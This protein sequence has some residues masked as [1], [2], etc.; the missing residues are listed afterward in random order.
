M[1]KPDKKANVG[2][3]TDRGYWKVCSSAGMLTAWVPFHDCDEAMGTITMIDGSNRWSGAS[4]G[5]DFFSNDLE[6]IEKN[7]NNGK[8]PVVKAPMNLKKG[9]ASFHSCLTIHGSGPN[10]GP[11]PR[12]SIAIHLQDDSNQWQEAHWGNGQLATHF[13]DRLVRKDESGRP[14]YTDPA[15]CPTLWP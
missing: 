9:C 11:V 5:L 13:N 14:D 15:I 3:H 1:D 7:F 10:S 4:E 8:E 12:R 2:W 6:G